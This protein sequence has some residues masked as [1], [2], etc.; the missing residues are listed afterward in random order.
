MTREGAELRRRQGRRYIAGQIKIDTLLA[1]GF[2]LIF[3][4]TILYFA[5]TVVNP[6]PF[7]IDTFKKVLALA[8]GGIAAVIP[9]QFEIKHLPFVRAGGA[10]AVF[11]AVFFAPTSVVTPVTQLKAPT[12]DP[13]PV[14]E[15]WFAAVDSGDYQA[16]WNQ[17]DPA[18]AQWFNLKIENFVQVFQN[19]RTPLGKI[20]SRRLTNQGDMTN[21]PNLPPGIYRSF[22]Y[23]S[24]F[25]KSAQCMTESLAVRATDELQ[26]RVFSHQIS[27]VPVPCVG[28][29]VG[30]SQQ[31]PTTSSVSA[32]AEY[33][34]Q[35]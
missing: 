18:T 34:Q 22:L 3:V 7:Q 8:A 33:P 30:S 5:V 31:A 10:L 32:T 21:P 20:I 12:Q 27:Y 9:G 2:G 28:M 15:K 13:A 24:K 4:S 19:T 26:W 6:T 35:N 1:F 23:L 25:E 17:A 14:V 29:E 11:A 16:A